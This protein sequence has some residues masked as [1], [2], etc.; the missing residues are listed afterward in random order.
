[1]F[2]LAAGLLFPSVSLL[3]ALKEALSSFPLTATSFWCLKTDQLQG[4]P[5]SSRLSSK[6]SGAQ[7]FKGRGGRAWSG[8]DHPD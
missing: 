3:W 5:D 8:R 7:K 1:M 2:V 6:A 4:A